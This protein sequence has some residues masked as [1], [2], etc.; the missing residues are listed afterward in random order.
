MEDCLELTK[1]LQEL[2]SASS[3][4]YPWAGGP[5]PSH[6]NSSGSAGHL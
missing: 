6:L 4:C 1:G 3:R 5:A 2:K